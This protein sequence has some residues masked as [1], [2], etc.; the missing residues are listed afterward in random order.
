MNALL[1][2]T[3]NLSERMT[4]EGVWEVIVVVEDVSIYRWED[5]RQLWSIE[6]DRL[7]IFVMA[8]ERWFGD[9][10]GRR[11]GMSRRWTN[12][13]CGF[14]SLALRLGKMRLGITCQPRRKL[15]LDY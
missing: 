15:C 10:D 13:G 12:T 6:S 8:S 1:P 7:M 4:S 5:D 3:E 11:E 2:R 14:V 9:G